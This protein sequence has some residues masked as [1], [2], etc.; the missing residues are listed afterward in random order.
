MPAVKATSRIAKNGAAH[1]LRQVGPDVVREHEAR[2]AEGCGDERRAAPQGDARRRRPTAQG[3]AEED[4]RAAQLGREQH[5]GE[6]LEPHDQAEES[7]YERAG[8][9]ARRARQ[10]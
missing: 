6:H 7:A 3:D 5:L 8:S 1:V 2:P 4:A 10:G 9:N